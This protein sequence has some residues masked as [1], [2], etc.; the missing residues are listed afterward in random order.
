MW[1]GERSAVAL[2]AV[3]QMRPPTTLADESV[4]ERSKAGKTMSTLDH[5]TLHG[6]NALLDSGAW[7]RLEGSAGMTYRRN[8]GF[9]ILGDLLMSGGAKRGNPPLLWILS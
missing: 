1:G 7:S 6:S 9:K 5:Q 2:G 8:N 3:A 4:G